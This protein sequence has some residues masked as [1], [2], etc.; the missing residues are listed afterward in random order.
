MTLGG[1]DQF[2]AVSQGVTTHLAAPDGFGWAPLPPEQAKELWHYTQFAY[3]DAELPLNW[4][5]PDAYLNMFDGRILSEPISASTALRCPH[6]CDGMGPSPG[7][8]R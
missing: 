5:T 2:A 6:R 7:N 4:Q 1:R 8:H 3:G